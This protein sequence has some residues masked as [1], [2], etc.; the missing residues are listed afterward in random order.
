LFFKEGLFFSALSASWKVVME[1][2][3]GDSVFKVSLELI[4]LLLSYNVGKYKTIFVF[5]CY[6]GRENAVKTL[7]MSSFI[8]GLT[9]ITRLLCTSVGSFS[10]GH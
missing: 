10:F 3:Y 5:S 4:R 6:S 8:R 7:F 1:T 9:D 2:F